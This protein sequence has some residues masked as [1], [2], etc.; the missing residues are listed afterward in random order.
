MCRLRII[1]CD[2]IAKAA[3][4]SDKKRLCFVRDVVMFHDMTSAQKK[5]AEAVWK[6][7]QK[8]QAALVADLVRVLK[9]AAESSLTATLK[10][11]ERD[12][13]LDI[14]GGREKGRPRVI[15]LTNQGRFD[16]GVGGIPLLG[17]IPAG[18]L[19]EA[20]AQADEIVEAM[21]PS[22]SGDFLLRVRGDSMIGDGIVDGD[23]VL[24]RPDVTPRE[25][26]IAAVLVGDAFETTLKRVF[27][28]PGQVILRASNPKYPDKKVLANDV[29]I[30]GVFRGLIRHAGGK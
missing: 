25:G 16:L 12:G 9:Y 13:V 22:R 17:S 24:L 21:L 20:L 19:D 29:R 1:G 2:R 10:I 4:K 14:R 11:M 30:A 23:L 18:P 3:F 15:S 28:S 6:F 8:G 7:Q 26:E 5:I 27:S